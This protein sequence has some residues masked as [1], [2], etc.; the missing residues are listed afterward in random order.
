MNRLVD[1]MR[2]AREN[3][4]LPVRFRSADVRQVY[5][6]LDID[7]YRRILARHRLGNA[8]GFTVYFI[9]HEDGS[10]SFID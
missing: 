9:Q 2:R 5:P 1:A 10:Y 4:T 6:G 8:G 7:S 3:G